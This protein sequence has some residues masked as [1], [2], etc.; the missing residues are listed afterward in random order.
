MSQRRDR[1]RPRP[2][3]KQGRVTQSSASSSDVR[4]GSPTGQNDRDARRK[5]ILIDH[6]RRTAKQPRAVAL[7]MPA[8]LSAHLRELDTLEMLLG[9]WSAN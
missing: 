5:S 2:R 8:Q 9:D 6:R 3:R 1:S 4:S 7:L